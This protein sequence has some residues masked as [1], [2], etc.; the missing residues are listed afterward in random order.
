MR[1]FDP[2]P[3][4]SHSRWATA[5]ALFGMLGVGGCRTA[6][7][8]RAPEATPGAGRADDADMLP[9]FETQAEGEDGVERFKVA[10]GD[11]PARGPAN[12]PVT[13]VMFSDFECPFCERGHR[14]LEALQRKYADEV[15][16]VYKA[17]PLDMHSNALLAAM[18]ARTAQEQGKFWAFHDQLYG[19]A[20]LDVPSLLGYARKVGMDVAALERNLDRLTHAAEVRRDMRQARRLGVTSTPHFFIN[21]RPLTG[22]QPFEAFDE[23]VSE[24]LELAEQWRAEGVPAD[25]IYEHAIK[26]GYGEVVY[27]RRGRGLDPDGV[28]AVPLGKSPRRGP[29]TA[30]VTIVTFGDFECP[31]CVRGHQTV[32]RILERYGDDVRLVYKHHPLAFHSHAFIAARAS[33]AAHAQGKFWEFHDAIYELEAKFDEKALRALAK[34]IGLDMRKFDKA[35]NSVELDAQIEADLSLAMNLGVTGTPAFFVN[36]RP[37]EGAVPELQFRLMLEEELGRARAALKEG[38]PP[39]ELYETLTHRR[40]D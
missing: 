35:M 13:I 25:A 10:V 14:T 32:E 24:E 27:T 30:P 28:F 20:S 37:L 12:A 6:E 21:G 16:I 34:R 39:A 9:A 29:D 26:D 19:G 18:A 7:L 31:F 38:V 40:L 11:A 3:P 36:G 2:L 33:M 8:A 5:L 1:R 22:A 15:R 4:R 23:I 17:Y